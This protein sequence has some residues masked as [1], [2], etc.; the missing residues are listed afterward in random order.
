M[1]RSDH[2]FPCRMNQK[3]IEEFLVEHFSSKIQVSNLNNI[4]LPS[5]QWGYVSRDRPLMNSPRVTGHEP[6]LW[7]SASLPGSQP[8]GS[9]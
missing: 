6:N 2:I 8:S 7:A 1:V 9:A 5:Y 3:R 4:M